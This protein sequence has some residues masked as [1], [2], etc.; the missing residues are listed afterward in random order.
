VLT[1]L[2]LGATVQSLAGGDGEPSIVLGY[3]D[4]LGYLPSANAYQG[5][6]VGRYANRVA[7]S[8]FTLDNAE[9]RLDANHGQNSLHGGHDGYHQR[10]WS[11]VSHDDSTLTLGLESPDGDQGFPGALHVQARYEVA[12]G[13]V[14]ITLTATCDRGQSDQ[15]Q[16]LQPECERVKRRRP[17]ARGRGLD[18]ARAS[19]GR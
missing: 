17:P 15:P 19:R 13:S 6:V 3:D 8:R 1:V 5:A 14:T 4:V 18:S 7:R 16:L 11:L 9:Y 12:P 2:D 10:V